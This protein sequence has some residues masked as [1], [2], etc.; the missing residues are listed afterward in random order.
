[1]E[2]EIEE[3]IY[4]TRIQDSIE[5]RVTNYTGFKSTP[6][7]LSIEPAEVDTLLGLRRYLSA[8]EGNVS[9]YEGNFNK[10]NIARWYLCSLYEILTSEQSHKKF[11]LNTSKG[12][13]D[14]LKEDAEE[15]ANF[16]KNAIIGAA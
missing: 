4:S 14:A 11:D 12:I 2:E 15:T 7:E 9:L 3:K 5:R 8:M 6:K 16:F 10:F 1:M 13:D